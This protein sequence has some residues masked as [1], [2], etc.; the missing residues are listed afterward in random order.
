MVVTVMCSQ[1]YHSHCSMCSN[2]KCTIVTG[3][4][5]NVPK[6]PP[7][8]RH[9]LVTPL[10][11]L[12]CF[13]GENS[14]QSIAGRASWVTTSLVL[15]TSWK[16]NPKSKPEWGYHIAGHRSMCYSWW[17]SYG[18]PSTTGEREGNFVFVVPLK[19]AS[20]WTTWQGSYTCCSLVMCNHAV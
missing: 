12:M 7:R 17:S 11:C 19:V 20:W 18:L 14:D 5:K 10:D 6:Y 1:T 3:F 16:W 4:A 2:C 15:L 9:P 13:W 8:P